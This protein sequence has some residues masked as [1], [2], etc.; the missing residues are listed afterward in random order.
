LGT[1]DVVAQIAEVSTGDTV[2]ADVARTST[3]V[4]TVTFAVAPSTNQYR[5]IIKK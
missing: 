4:V 3:S 1:L 2:Y 5:V